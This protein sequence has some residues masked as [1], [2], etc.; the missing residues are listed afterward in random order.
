[1]LYED[2]LYEGLSI[3]LVAL[4][5][6]YKGRYRTKIEE[7]GIRILSIGVPIAE[8]QFVPLREGTRLEIVFVDE[9]SAYSFLTSIIKR[10][11]SPLPTFIVEAPNQI[12][13]IKDALLRV[14][15]EQIYVWKRGIREAKKVMVD[16][17]EGGC[18]GVSRIFRKNY[19]PK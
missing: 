10:I 13:K 17:A 9:I 16:L 19:L 3:E 6:E 4:E 11:A 15:D 5:G 2:K 14:R 18:H 8:G 1:M 7:I 12:I